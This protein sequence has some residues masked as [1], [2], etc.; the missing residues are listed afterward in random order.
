M[1]LLFPT[2]LLCVIT[3]A[4]AVIDEAVKPAVSSPSDAVDTKSKNLRGL[5]NES[6][7]GNNGQSNKVDII[8]SLSTEAKSNGILKKCEDKANGGTARYVYKTVF[9]GCTLSVPPGALNSLRNDIEIDTVELDGEVQALGVIQSP[10]WSQDRIDQ[11]TGRD[12][13]PYTQ[14]DAQGVRMYIIDTGIRTSHDLLKNY[15]NT[16]ST[17]NVDCLAQ[18]SNGDC[19]GSTPLTDGNGHG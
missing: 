1:N 11:Q 5:A 10:I 8:V 18:N 15:I 14:V 13:A 9:G 3:A 4:S 16:A 2:C 17:C 19:T 7:N 6:N 12:D